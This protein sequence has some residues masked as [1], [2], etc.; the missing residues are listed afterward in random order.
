MTK[1]TKPTIVRVKNRKNLVAFPGVRVVLA[2]AKLKRRR[3]VG[4]EVVP[5]SKG[6]GGVK[7]PIYEDV[8]P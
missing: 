5:N 7:K 4:Y 1:T 6:Y 3:L 2:R 8:A